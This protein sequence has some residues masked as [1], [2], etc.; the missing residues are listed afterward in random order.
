MNSLIMNINKI[1]NVKAAHFG[2]GNYYDNIKINIAA[3]HDTIDGYLNLCSE[4]R[5]SYSFV[6]QLLKTGLYFVTAVLQRLN[7][8]EALCLLGLRK[9]WFKE[10]QKYWGN[11]LG[12]RP[13]Q[14]LDFY[15]LYHE[16]RKK[17]QMPD[18]L[19]WSS[20][21]Q[22]ICNWQNPVHLFSIFCYARL[23]TVSPI[24]PM[25]IWKYLPKVG[26]YLEYGCSLAPYYNCSKEFLIR[27]NVRWTLADIPGFAFH[28]A[29]YRYNEHPGVKFITV[30]DFSNPL[31]GDQ[32]FDVI[33]LTTV[34]EHVD[35]PVFLVNYLFSKMNAGGI[36]VFDYIKSDGTGLDCPS[37]LENRSECIDL[38]RQRTK[39]LSGK[40]DAEGYLPL[41]V[42][43]L[44]R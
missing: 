8:L 2:G 9:K 22:H 42:V 25:H 29:K 34:L 4:N 5:T 7:L 20:P 17:Q 37:A 27:P 40:L 16:Y 36:L 31:P 14:I 12:G 13:I 33:I 43:K 1:A 38:I 41:T 18:K 35:D 44:V 10:F 11:C 24:V 21:E 39:V 6:L 28:Y 15:L 26:N 32:A 23:Q 3:S 19:N 30:Q